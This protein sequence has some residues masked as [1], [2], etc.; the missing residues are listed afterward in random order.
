MSLGC[1]CEFSPDHDFIFP[2]KI[3]FRRVFPNFVLLF[4]INPINPIKIQHGF[5]LFTLKDVIV[6]FA[7]LIAVSTRDLL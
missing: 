5:L 7:R 6:I 4:E 3:L 1:A 2:K